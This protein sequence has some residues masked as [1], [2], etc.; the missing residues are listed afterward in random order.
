MADPIIVHLTDYLKSG[1]PLAE[2]LRQF[3]T[4]T[5]EMSGFC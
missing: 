1:H 4:A 2:F 5:Q 3:P